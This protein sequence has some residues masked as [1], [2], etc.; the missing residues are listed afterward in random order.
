MEKSQID[1]EMQIRV[2]ELLSLAPPTGVVGFQLNSSLYAIRSL[3]VSVWTVMVR[4]GQRRSYMFR[5]GQRWS[6]MIRD[7]PRW[8]EIVRDC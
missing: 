1:K 6:V 7:G 5:D 8:S 4:D 3:T 2:E